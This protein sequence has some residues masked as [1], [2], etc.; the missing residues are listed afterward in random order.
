VSPADPVAASGQLL[1]HY[2]IAL[3]TDYDMA[4]IR[5]RVRT[6]GS[7]LDQRAGLI[8][9]AYC[10]R[11]IG[12][13]DSPVNQYAPFYI[14]ADSAAA[15]DFLWGGAG[16]EGIVRDFGR[17]VVPTWV[18]TAQFLGRA[19]AGSV[20]RAQLRTTAIAPDA[21]LAEVA[22]E[23][24]GR[25]RR[26]GDDEQVHLALGGIDP[27]IWQTVEFTTI[28]NDPSGRSTPADELDE[29][30]GAGVT[31]TVLHVSQPGRSS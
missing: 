14:W 1:M 25:V 30:Y 18:P 20:T 10:V 8:M 12:V 23:L 19:P 26:R 9:K 28:G 22:A 13:D 24:I 3:P 7:A 29:R 6:R 5:E 2:P 11:E 21:E 15:A 16:F 27:T 4:I 31:F 17:P